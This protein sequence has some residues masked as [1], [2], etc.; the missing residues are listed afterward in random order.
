MR[1]FRSVY[2]SKGCPKVVHTLMLECWD[3]DKN[4]R[5]KFSEI[6]LRLDGLIRSPECLKDNSLSLQYK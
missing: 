1:L 5:L 6:L 2:L 3:K 4:K